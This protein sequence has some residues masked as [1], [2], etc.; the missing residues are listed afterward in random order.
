MRSAGI[1][2]SALRSVYAAT[3]RAFRQRRSLLLLN[4]QHQVQIEEL[5]WVAAME[6]YRCA[7]LAITD[8]AAQALKEVTLLYLNAFPHV[9]FPNK[10]LQE[11][12]ALAQA[13]K[14]EI[15]LVDE[16]GVDIFMGMIIEQQQILT[17]Q[18]LA[19]LLVGLELVDSLARFAIRGSGYFPTCPGRF[20]RAL[21]PWLV[22]G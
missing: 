16:L 14:V 17:T 4:L 3:Y 22:P 9:I 10:L 20:W 11:L 19:S 5:P 21:F 6:R 13:A 7:D 1:L 8:A 2:D 15:P 12:R 18:N